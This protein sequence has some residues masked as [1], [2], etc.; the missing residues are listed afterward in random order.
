MTERRALGLE[1]VN[2]Y[3]DHE[4][5]LFGFETL[6]DSATQHD[7][8]DEAMQV[9]EAIWRGE[10]PIHFTGQHDRVHGKMRGPFPPG[11]RHHS[12]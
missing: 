2:G 8:C 12:W 10:R 1:H 3:H 6:A 9:I 4:A 11:R 7:A 5:S